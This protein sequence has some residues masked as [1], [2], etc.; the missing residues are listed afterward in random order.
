MSK[1]D[2]EIESIHYGLKD[3][4]SDLEGD[5][6]GRVN[7]SAV[8]VEPAENCCTYLADGGW[9]S[10]VCGEPLPCAKHSEYRCDCGQP[11]THG[12]PNAGSLVCGRPCCDEHFECQKHG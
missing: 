8:S 3:V 6:T 7:W 12:C 4:I 10:W 11:A 5:V 2:E 1:K 9:T